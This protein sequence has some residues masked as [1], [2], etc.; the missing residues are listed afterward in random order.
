[1]ASHVCSAQETGCKL[2]QQGIDGRPKPRWRNLLYLLL[3][4][5]STVFWPLASDVAG[6]AS[7][8]NEISGTNEL[9]GWHEQAAPAD[10]P[11]RLAFDKLWLPVLQKE[12]AA[13]SFSHNGKSFGRIDA[14]SWRNLI[15]YSQNHTESELLQM[16]NGFFNQWPAQNDAKSWDTNEHWATPGEFLHLRRGDCED[17]AITK[18]FALRFLGMEASR[19][20]I[21]I[22]RQ[23][24]EDGKFLRQL[25]AVLAVQRG[26]NWFILDNNA[27]PRDNV[28]PQTMYRGRFVPLYSINEEGAWIYSL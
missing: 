9:F 19:L 2:W 18:Y 1:M 26:P 3:F 17:Y 15:K 27:V 7:R 13:P 11:Y 22:V 4:I 12:R 14:T 28:F 16:V 10:N 8:I 23:K 20:R 24:G 25:H 5:L 21:V 6:G